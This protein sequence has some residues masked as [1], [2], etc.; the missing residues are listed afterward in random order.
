MKIKS[1]FILGLLILNLINSV[2]SGGQ[3]DF[4]GITIKQGF[5]DVKN[6]NPIITQ[7]FSADPGVM[8][9]NDRV[10]VYQLMMVCCNQVPLEKMFIPKLLNL[11]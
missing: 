10:Y 2:F 7:K 3:E 1:T 11:I 5:K 8:V 4:N 9:Y 6:H